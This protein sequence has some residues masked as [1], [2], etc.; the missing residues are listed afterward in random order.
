M[1]MQSLLA[2][3]DSEPITIADIITHLKTQGVFRNALQ[4]LVEQRVIAQQCEVFGIS[5]SAEEL[6]Q[7]GETKRRLLGFNDTLTLH[8][9]C[10]TQ[11]ISL[12]QW[13]AMIQTEIQRSKLKNRVINALDIERYFSLHKHE[14]LMAVLSRIV[15]AT[16]AEAE[17]CKQRLESQGENFAQLASVSSIEKTTRLAGGYLGAIRYGTLPPAINSAVFSA[18]PGSVHGPFAMAGYWVIFRV[19]EFTQNELCG[20]LQ[21]RIGEQLFNEWLQQRM[22]QSVHIG[23]TELA[24]PTLAA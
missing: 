10:R 12:T 6:Q 3:V 23:E 9:H 1:N 21:R 4:Q 17:Y 5:V 15:C 7:H 18:A 14:F 2:R 20:S 24:I 22:A 19:N 11:G 13:N 8:K 16:Q